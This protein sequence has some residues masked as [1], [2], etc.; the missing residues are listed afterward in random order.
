MSTC[1]ERL[2]R[3]LRENGVDFEA[4]THP[5]VYTAQEVA[6]VQHVSG[7]EIAKVVIALADG[8]LIMLVLSGS[9][10]VNV[11]KA[12]AALGAREMRLAHEDEFAATFPDCEVGAMPPFGNL[13][14]VPVLV[15]GALAEDEKIVFQAGT[16]ADTLVIRYADYEKL[17]E[18][19]VGDFAIAP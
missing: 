9:Y 16:H 13:Y 19:K 5:V 17:V 1:K 18:P 14:N 3:Y 6:A 2:V 10:K 4:V 12:A 8:S 15:D 11:G 7:K